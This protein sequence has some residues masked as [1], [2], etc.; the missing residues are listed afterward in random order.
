MRTSAA[1]PGCTHTAT[2]TSRLS[3]GAT[4]TAAPEPMRTPRRVGVRAEPKRDEP[5]H[6]AVLPWAGVDAERR[7]SARDREPVV[8]EPCGGPG[9]LPGGARVDQP[10][11]ARQRHGGTSD[12]EPCLA[13]ALRDVAGRRCRRPAC[14]AVEREAQPRERRLDLGEAIAGIRGAGDRTVPKLEV[15]PEG[16]SRPVIGLDLG[17][18]DHRHVRGRADGPVDPVE[19]DPL[20]HGDRSSRRAVDADQPVERVR[21]LSRERRRCRGDENDGY[22][23][24]RREPP[25]E[26]EVGKQKQRRGDQQGPAAVRPYVVVEGGDRHVRVQLVEHRKRRQ[27][28]PC[29][30]QGERSGE[31]PPRCDSVVDGADEPDEEERCA[32]EEVAVSWQVAPEPEIE[33]RHLEEQRGDREDEYERGGRTPRI[34]AEPGSAED[35]RQKPEPESE[36]RAMLEERARK[37]GADNRPLCCGVVRPE[38]V[39][40]GKRRGDRCHDSHRSH[41]REQSMSRDAPADAAFPE[42]DRDESHDDQERELGACDDGEPD[43]GDRT[44]IPKQRRLVDRPQEQVH[45]PHE[46]RIGNG[47]REDERRQHEP[48][49]ENGQRGRSVGAH[50]SGERASGDEVGGDR[51]R[52]H[53]HRVERVGPQEE[54]GYEAVACDRSEQHR[55]QLVRRRHA[56]AAQHRERRTGAGD[57]EREPLV[58]QLVAHHEPVD[59]PSRRDR[60]CDCRAAPDREHGQRS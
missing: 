48:R 12:L 16:C 60:D 27:R 42:R 47:L 13:V 46:G 20:R 22:E 5:H 34:G 30:D 43:P 49:H 40:P 38:Y 45:R 29:D 11:V 32:V 31:R 57:A 6:R 17:V 55:V 33:R 18:R 7:G 41:A 4:A 23:P 8:V 53:E 10:D 3:P 35:R 50:A 1:R 25:R 56:Y 37:A 36:L 52:R 2:G 58:E 9:R 15:P 44:R 19:H 21:R 24:S 28:E 54:R 59:D 39:V 14:R 26:Q 51:R